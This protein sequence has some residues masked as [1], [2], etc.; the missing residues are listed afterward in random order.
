[1]ADYNSSYGDKIQAIFDYYGSGTTIWEKIQLGTATN[2]EINFAL[3]RIPQL[4][5]D[6]TASGNVLG[7]SYADPVYLQT[8]VNEILNNTNS[9][10]AGGQYGN[11]NA[12]TPRFNGNFNFDD[13]T[14]EYSVSTGALDGLGNVVKTVADRVNLGVMGVNIGAKLG[15]A[16]DET[17]YN[18]DPEWWDTHYPTINPETWTTIAGSEGGENF[19]RTLFDIKD[20][21][22]TSYVSSE[23][24]A[25]T[26]QMLRDLGIFED[27]AQLNPDEIETGENVHLEFITGTL[28]DL[29]MQI[30]G[31]PLSRSH[32]GTAWENTKAIVG[33]SGTKVWIFTNETAGND[34]TIYDEYTVRPS[35]YDTG[36]YTVNKSF[37]SGITLMWRPSNGSLEIRGSYNARLYNVSNGPISGS[38]AVFVG[39]YTPI[40]MHN[41][42]GSTQYPPTNITGTDL[43]TVLQQLKNEYPQLFTDPI[44]ETVKQPDGTLKTIEYVPVP[45]CNPNVQ[46]TTKP[47]TGTTTQT[48]VEVAPETGDK[49][50]DKSPLLPPTEKF[51]DTG[52]GDSPVPVLP[53]GGSSSLWSVYNPTQAE[54]NSFGAWLWSSDFVEQLKKMF[55]DPMQAIIGIHKVFA[56]PE[57]GSRANIKCGYIDSGVSALTVSSQY[58]EINCGSV[59]LLE[60]FG[61]VFDYHPYTSVRV[62]LPF[63]G[64]VP[65]N[66]A[67]VMRSTISIKY[68]VDV[69]TGACV[70]EISVNRDAHK[71]VIY[72][73]SGSAIVSYPLS[74]GSYA[75]VISAAIGVATSLISGSVMGAVASASMARAKTEVNGSFSGAPGAMGGKKPYLI[76]TRPISKL[77]YGENTFDG[78]PSGE[79]E[80]IGNCVGFIKCFDV[81]LRIDTATDT[82]LDEIKEL[83]LEGVRL[84]SANDGG[85]IAEPDDIKIQSLYVTSNGIYSNEDISGYMPVSVEVPPYNTPSQVGLVVDTNGDLVTQSEI[86]INANGVYDTT[87]NN[88]VIVSVGGGGGSYPLWS[89]IYDNLPSGVSV[90][91]PTITAPVLTPSWV[92]LTTQNVQDFINNSCRL[93]TRPSAT[94]RTVTTNITKVMAQKNINQV[95]SDPAYFGGLIEYYGNLYDNTLLTTY[96]MVLLG[97]FSQQGSSSGNVLLDA[98]TNYSAIA[99]QGIYNKSRTSQYNT[100]IIY[101]VEM[102]VWIW[103]GM[104]DRNASYNTNVNFTNAQTVSLNGKRQVII[105]GIP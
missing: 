64:I 74:S 43:Q 92:A 44:Y 55:N 98:I 76:I 73:Y 70:A 62:F 78:Y 56:T 16:I 87:Y 100:T 54:V 84:T 40:A 97:D 34:I 13:N 69:I 101:P 77:A 83:L 66:V 52:S 9:N 96:N 26:Y 38:T 29:S 51:P 82:E 104:K 31:I 93:S 20:G 39:D 99:L 7:F 22:M 19:I 28:S 46:D 36:V 23:V 91:T 47:T 12:F 6:Q 21:G 27:H 88:Q 60:Y 24:F 63:I 86:T 5:V 41:I 85:I 14:G 50:L 35:I 71:S 59:S 1:M 58:T 32:I 18:I 103:S 45:W 8:S 15:K 79:T 48:D 17:I 75:G 53:V 49:I 95:I 2:D 61:N 68:K 37:T 72:T 65:L 67:D 10:Y 42:P 30:F 80:L 25:Q 4:Q 81:H 33:Y 94:G 105:Y 89:D 11:G 90:S 57:T 102:N 3:S